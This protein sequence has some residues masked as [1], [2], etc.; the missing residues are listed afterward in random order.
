MVLLRKYHPA[1]WT[2]RYRWA[3]EVSRSQLFVS[4][5]SG[6]DN[7]WDLRTQRPSPL[8]DYALIRHLTSARIDL[9]AFRGSIVGPTD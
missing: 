8:D 6:S 9:I 5:P 4:L 2:V 1:L 7:G 3:A